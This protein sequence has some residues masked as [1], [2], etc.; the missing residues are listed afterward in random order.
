ME[1]S[2]GKTLCF[3]FPA[4]FEHSTWN[5]GISRFF[6]HYGYYETKPTKLLTKLKQLNY[7]HKCQHNQ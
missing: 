6:Y 5:D 1:E 7:C 2:S 3:L 4:S